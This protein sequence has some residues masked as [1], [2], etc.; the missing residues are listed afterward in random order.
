MQNKLAILIVNW[1]THVDVG[2]ILK[3]TPKQVPIVIVDNNSAELHKLE[4]VIDGFSNC[5]LVRSPVNGGYG[6]G[7]NLAVRYVQSNSLAENV[8]LLN[9]DVYLTDAFLNHV[10][11]ACGSFDIL[12][13]QQ[14]ST[15]AEGDRNYYPCAAQ[16]ESGKIRL[17]PQQNSG[18]ATADVVTGAAMLLDLSAFDGMELFDEDFFHYKE[19]F[20]FCFRMKSA[21]KTIAIDY[22]VP[23]HHKSGASLAH[24]SLSAIYYQVRN[25]IIFANKHRTISRLTS[26]VNVTAVIKDCITLNSPGKFSAIA[27]AIRDGLLSKTG[28]REL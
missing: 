24:G 1:N 19:E 10:E 25:E 21:G 26:L 27:K 16:V 20:D 4:E 22:D 14:Y 28:A 2:E 5:F 11:S 9:P 7:M 23:L 12:G 6:A 15:N 8:L 13:F 3:A 18:R 17:V